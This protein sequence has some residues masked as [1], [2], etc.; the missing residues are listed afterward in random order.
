LPERALEWG[1]NLIASFVEGIKSGPVIK[2]ITGVADTI[3]RF[4]G[5]GS[6]TEAGPG[7]TADLWAPRFVE[8]FAQGLRKGLPLVTAASVELASALSGALAGMVPAV[9]ASVVPAMLSP[10]PAIE[11]VAPREMPAAIAAPARP[12]PSVPVAA[13]PPVRPV[14]V[15]VPV[16]RP[17]GEATGP[18]R[19]RPQA[20]VIQLVVDGRVLAEVVRNIEREDLARSAPW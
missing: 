3:K 16:E 17:A 18:A 6:P 15:Q 9:P 20:E 5:F 2:A 8:M 11:A 12:Q 13:I 7:A 19:G 14:I 4:L 10:V 1:R